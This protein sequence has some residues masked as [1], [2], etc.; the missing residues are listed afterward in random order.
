MKKFH[1][2]KS[3]SSNAVMARRIMRAP[4]DHGTQP[5]GGDN[6]Q[7]NP[8][9]S[10]NPNP[11]S[12][13]T[14]E[15]AELEAF[16]GGQTDPNGDGSNPGDPDPDDSGQSDTATQLGE[17][18]NGFDPGAF[19]DDT[20]AGEINEGNFQNVNER[21]VTAQ[22]ATMRQTMQMSAML[23]RAYGDRLL[24]QV[25][26]EMA[27]MFEGRDDQ[28]QLTRDFPAAADPVVGP[29]IQSVFAQALKNAKG[30]R[31]AAVTQ[32]KKM[33]SLMARRT[34]GD[35]NLNVAPRGPNDVPP[36]PTTDWLDELGV[37]Q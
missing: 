37:R 24:E 13:N 3:R 35:L 4:D 11:D 2:Y 36:T 10:S 1:L 17:M 18:L 7:V 23:M 25:R 22:R 15:E 27:G 21:F 12:T 28:T 31:A 32:T 26:G 20:L 6:Q 29:M 14:G 5:A 8:G 34:G 9:D 30:N 16:W 33:I 19:F